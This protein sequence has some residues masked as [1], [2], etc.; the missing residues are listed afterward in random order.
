MQNAYEADVEA[1]VAAAKARAQEE[2]AAADREIHAK[3]MAGKI[4]DEEW[5]NHLENRVRESLDTEEK[6]Q[7][8][9]MLLEHRGAIEDAQIEARFA[10]GQVSVGALMQHYSRRMGNVEKN[11]PAWRELASRYGQ[12]SQAGVSGGGGGGGGGGRRGGG[13]GG[14]SKSGASDSDVVGAGMDL[15]QSG[16]MFRGIHTG[17]RDIID[18]TASM[19]PIEDDDDFINSLLSDVERID[20]LVDYHAEHPDDTTV[21]DET[22]GEVFEVNADFWTAIDKQYIR[23]EQALA[24]T[25]FARGTSEDDKKGV[26][27]LGH[28]TSYVAGPMTEHNT[29]RAKPKVQELEQFAFAEVVAASRIADPVERQQAYDRAYRVI[30]QYSDRHI[31]GQARQVTQDNARSA[32]DLRLN[33]TGAVQSNEELPD[34]LRPDDAT[35]TRI[36]TLLGVLDLGAHAGGMTPDE[37]NS[38]AD[39]ILSQS[40]T[41]GEGGSTISIETLLTG[42]GEDGT[43]AGIPDDFI[44]LLETNTQVQ[45]LAEGQRILAGVPDPEYDGPVYTYSY[46]GGKVRAV[47]ADVRDQPN[48]GG[49]VSPVLVPQGEDPSVMVMTRIKMGGSVQTVWATPQPVDDP[50]YRVYRKSNGELLTSAEIKAMGPTGLQ[51][52]VAN[53]QVKV[54]SVLTGVEMPDGRVWFRDNDTGMYHLEPPVQ[55]EQDSTTGGVQVT[56]EREAVVNHMPFAQGVMTPF[57]GVKAEDMQQW[58]ERAIAAGMLNPTAFRMRG[59]GGEAV[60]LTSIAGMY[61]TPAEVGP[62]KPALLLEDQI[63][64]R[65]RMGEEQF[66]AAGRDVVEGIR[67][68]A[69]P[70]VDVAD[71]TRRT[72]ERLGIGGLVPG[73]DKPDST[74]MQVPAPKR[75]N[76]TELFAQA[77]TALESRVKTK[78]AMFSPIPKR[79]EPEVFTPTPPPVRRAPLPLLSVD[80][81]QLPPPPVPQYNPVKTVKNPG[82]DSGQKKT[83]NAGG[84]TLL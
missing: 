24:A 37:I 40:A 59:A 47:I 30:K 46:E 51:A 11:S 21:I 84:A 77:T 17:G 26:M 20:M 57:A 12:L 5:L 54:D 75:Q 31:T 70:Q 69:R 39:A 71:Q 16:D 56:N 8:R 55:V 67:Q 73:R 19:R 13:G 10:L 6:S 36:N 41:L 63:R 50:R 44:G 53:E 82:A 79:I 65:Q 14:G 2:Q 33:V 52:M 1:D 3:W 34:A 29:E 38:R 62:K 35:F 81:R 58:T 66:A 22:T 18:P 64:A 27:A 61:Y 68:Q 76:Y 74:Y 60:N 43:A 83:P 45:G 72:A 9:E 7:Y 25:Y 23:T 80:K 42:P 78:K 48:A 32:E 15:L 28:A 49:G 4:S